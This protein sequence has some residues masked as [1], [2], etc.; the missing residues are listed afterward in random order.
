MTQPKW[1]WISPSPP[2]PRSPTDRRD[3]VLRNRHKLRPG[4]SAR[5]RKHYRA[6]A[7]I[8]R[9]TSNAVAAARRLWPARLVVQG[10]QYRF[11]RRGTR[12]ETFINGPDSELDTMRV[13]DFQS[14]FAIMERA[15]LPR[16][17]RVSGY[18]A[19]RFVKIENRPYI[20]C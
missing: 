11:V 15:T 19:I 10:V 13:I 6:L 20:P 3:S 1:Q 8:E 18:V 2:T 4:V 16:D 7:D 17:K 12:L 14:D 9:L 5:A